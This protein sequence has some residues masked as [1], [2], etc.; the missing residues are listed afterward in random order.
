MGVG[1]MKQETKELIEENEQLKKIIEDLLHNSDGCEL[2]IAKGQNAPQ[3]QC[4]NDKGCVSHILRL[5]KE[6]M[7]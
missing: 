4:M 7:Q 2:C 5:Y 3:C 6:A 1:G